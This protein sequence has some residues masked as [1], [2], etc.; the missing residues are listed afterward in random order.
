M[1]YRFSNILSAYFEFPTE[2]AR[3]LLPSHLEPVELHHG[4]SVLSIG[5]F[6]VVDSPVGN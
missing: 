2:N 6:D 5:L 3:R 4:A 1:E